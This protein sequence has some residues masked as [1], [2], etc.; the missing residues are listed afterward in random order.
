M[1]TSKKFLFV[2]PDNTAGEFDSSKLFPVSSLQGIQELNATSVR[3]AVSDFGQA[4]DTL[5][6]I[7]VD[8]GTAKTYIK[9]LVEAINFAK[10]SVINLADASDETSFSPDVDFG[11][12]PVIT[13]GS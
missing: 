8:S 1:D 9:D 11:T 7:T 2:N 12:D 6:D 10:Q 3:L 13:V 4:D 5:I